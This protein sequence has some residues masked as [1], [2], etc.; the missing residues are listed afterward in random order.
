MNHLIRHLKVPFYCLL[1]VWGMAAIPSNA[2]TLSVSG[3]EDS[4][5]AGQ[6]FDFSITVRSQ[7]AYDR[8]AFPDSVEFRSAIQFLD[9]QQFRLS[10]FSDSTHYRLQF[11]STDD[12]VI[13]PLPVYVISGTDT[14]T[15]FTEP[16]QLYFRSVLAGDEEPLKPVKPNFLF[17][18][19]WWPFILGLLILAALAYFLYRKYFRP[20]EPEEEPVR[21]VPEFENPVV[22]LEQQLETIKEKHRQA[23]EK[24]YKWFYSELGDAL[25]LYIEELYNIP[26]L[27][28]TSREVFRYMDA[29]GVDTEMIKHMRSVLREA[30]MVKFAKFTP[31]LD[32]SMNAYHAAHSFLDRAKVV[33]VQRIERKREQFEARFNTEEDAKEGTH[34]MG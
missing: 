32:A 31:T 34:G 26:A 2:Q 33:D 16:Y 6:V 25:R 14:A 9:K 5:R 7:E 20:T 23:A 22:T 28:S 15:L 13:S 4:L 17:P 24:D 21:S 1:C 12:V 10:D 8:I 30:D 3:P 27:E 19:S 29:F 18:R 11:F